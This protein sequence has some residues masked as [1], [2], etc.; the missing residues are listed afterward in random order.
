MGMVQSEDDVS[1]S[2]FS[3]KPGKGIN[4]KGADSLWIR[5]L[6]SISRLR[7]ICPM[8]HGPI[9]R[10]DKPVR[11][12]SMRAGTLFSGRHF[13]VGRSRENFKAPQADHFV[14]ISS[15]YLKCDWV[16]SAGQVQSP[17]EPHLFE[18]N[19]PAV[20]TWAIHTLGKL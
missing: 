8:K 14:R 4:V 18:I 16:Y 12:R 17:I 7:E 10:V 3:H 20:L 2:Y 13:S 5:L 6:H 9:P 15:G 19:R 1:R 11:A